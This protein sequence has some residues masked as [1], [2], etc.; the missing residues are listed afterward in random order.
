MVAFAQAMPLHEYRRKRDP[1]RTNEPFG[2]EPP[3][4]G[5]APTTLGGYVVH[6]HD[7]TRT[8]YDLRV[9][10][11]GALA[12]FAVPKGPTLDPE[13]KHLA[14][15]TEDHPLEYLD[16]EAVIPAGQYGAGPM[17][18]WD[19]GCVRYVEAPAEEGLANGKLDMMLSGY[20]LNGRFALVRIKKSKKGNEW[21]LFK[22]RDAF[23]ASAAERNVLIEQPQSILC[24]LCID[25]LADAKRRARALEERAK[26]IGGVRARGEIGVVELREELSAGGRGS[27]SHAPLKSEGWVYQVK[28]DGA[29][30]LASRRADEV[31]LMHD[32]LDVT[33]FYPEIARAMRALPPERLVLDGDIVAMHDGRPSLAR[34]ATR[35]ERA[36]GE[37]ESTSRASHLTALELPVVFVLSD[38]RGVGD[39]DVSRAPLIERKQLLRALLPAPG[40]LRVADFIEHNGQALLDFAG[41]HDLEGIVAMPKRASRGAN[42]DWVLIRAPGAAKRP[43]TVRHDAD[44]HHAT[45]AQQHDLAARVPAR[46]TVTNRSKVFWPEDGYSKGDLCDYYEAVAP[47]LLPYLRDRPIALVRYPDGIHGKSF[48]QW[49][50]PLAMPSW[51]QTL[52]LRNDED[53][54][55]ERTIERRGF[56]VNDLQSLLYIANLGCIP[57]H[58]LAWRTPTLKRGPRRGKPSDVPFDEADFF[59][60]DFDVGASSLKEGVLLA[61]TLRSLLDAMGLVGFPKTSGQS[62]LH[63]LVPLGGGAT[64]DTAKMF[65]ELFGR[66]LVDRHPSSATMER[67][68]SKRGP[69][70]Y[71]DTGQTGRGRTIVA[72]YSVRAQLG[73]PVSMPLT[74]EEVDEALDP[75]RFT[76]RTAM[77][78]I[79]DNGDPM[80]P[81]LGMRADVGSAV[82]KMRDVLAGSSRGA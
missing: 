80:R 13:A 38:V 46:F 47:T 23:A 57:I 48:F 5:G 73:A 14:V 21:L 41:A 81:M 42:Q 3:G 63:V 17:I 19:R 76:I 22:K 34:L 15:H 45:V 68:V 70:V 67:V 33:A 4:E 35:I 59:T 31:V 54:D 61:R 26:A 53:D 44:G 78:R 25:E 40:V 71:V 75:K 56:L 79:V 16:F 69:K 28:L 11:G 50:V 74:W 9:E 7:A 72:P 66:M 64:F 55:G 32:G 1:R 6:L 39:L 62:G 2:P 20:K 18:L 77:A 30:V 24:G 37:V 82:A 43:R 12:S 52:A 27:Q 58:V 49:K 65:A 60:I 10:V 36:R 29:R 8:H 51:V